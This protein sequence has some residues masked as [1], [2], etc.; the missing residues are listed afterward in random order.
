MRRWGFKSCWVAIIIRHPKYTYA[1]GIKY[2]DLKAVNEKLK[3][4]FW[5]VGQKVME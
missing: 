2:Y 5:L 1:E 4:M 3:K